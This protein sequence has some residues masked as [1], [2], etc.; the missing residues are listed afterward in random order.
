MM[1]HWENQKRIN[2]RFVRKAVIT[3]RWEPKNSEEHARL[4]EKYPRLLPAEPVYDLS[5][6]RHTK[7]EEMSR[8]GLFPAP[9][10]YGPKRWREGDIRAWINEQ[11]A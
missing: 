1:K 11:A 5:G 3:K 7:T 6:Q 9:V 8:E 2:G 10:A 4:I